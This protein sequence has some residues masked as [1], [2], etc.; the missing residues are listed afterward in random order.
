ML[1]C[2]VSIKEPWMSYSLTHP[3]ALIPPELIGVSQPVTPEQFEKLCSEYRDLR[4]ELTSTG[5]LIVMPPTGSETGLREA[6]LTHQLVDWAKKDGTGVCFS[7]SAVFALPNSA[8]RSPDASW[9]RREKWERLT[10][11]EKE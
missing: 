2:C 5:E 11:R 4:L 7:A 10:A 1:G 3:H 6:N 9:V 8:R